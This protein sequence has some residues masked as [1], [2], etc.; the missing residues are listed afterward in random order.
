MTAIAMT[1]YGP[2]AAG[3]ERGRHKR[4]GRKRHAGKLIAGAA[5]MRVMA[6]GRRRH[7]GGGHGH[8]PGPGFDPRMLFGGMRGFGDLDRARELIKGS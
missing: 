2:F 1:D 6:E 4:H 8:G 7:H 3:A 5:L